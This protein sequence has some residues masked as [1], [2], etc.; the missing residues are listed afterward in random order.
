MEAQVMLHRNET[1]MKLGY[2]LTGVAMGAVATVF[3][4]PNSGSKTRKYLRR[5]ANAGA[6]YL[7]DCTAEMGKGT[8]EMVHRASE[9]I[10]SRVNRVARSVAAVCR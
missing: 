5:Q 1:N 3:V 7:K 10:Q 4:A 2:L 8:I 6:D 9:G